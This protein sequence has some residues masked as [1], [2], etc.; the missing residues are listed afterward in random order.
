MLR[1]GCVQSRLLPCG[2]CSWRLPLAS[3]PTHNHTAPGTSPRTITQH[4]AREMDGLEAFLTYADNNAVG[5]F[6]KQQFTK[7]VTLE[8][9]KARSWGGVGARGSRQ[10][11]RGAAGARAWRVPRRCCSS[12]LRLPLRAC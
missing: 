10:A 12:A 6:A 5:Y 9:E 4:Y 7:T 3:R 11:G 1:A 2:L 8:K